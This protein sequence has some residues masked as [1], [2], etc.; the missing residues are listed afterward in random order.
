MLV[1]AE[2]TFMTTKNNFGNEIP[3]EG[4]YNYWEGNKMEYIKKLLL[5]VGCMAVIVIFNCNIVYAD[6]VC[7]V[8]LGAIDGTNGADVVSSIRC[9][10]EK[11]DLSQQKV[12]VNVGNSGVKYGV[13][14]YDTYGKYISWTGW[15]AGTEYAVQANASYARVVLRYLDNRT[16]GR[17]ELRLLSECV[18]TQKTNEKYNVELGAIDGTNGADVVSSIRCRTEKYDLSQQKVNVN[19]GNSG[20]KYGVFFYDAYGKYISW[21]G[22]IAGTEYAVPAN[23]SYARVVLRY[24]DNRNISSNELKALNNFIKISYLINESE[25]ELPIL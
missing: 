17:S 8:E 10:T 3:W 25:W 18:T 16:I 15:L 12:N 21:T 23:A 20:I 24:D 19:V 2:N 4:A 13:F 1:G 5:I 14:F 22:W 11:Y 6:N 9:R 7:N